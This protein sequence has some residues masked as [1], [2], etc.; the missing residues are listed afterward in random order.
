MSP[1]PPLADEASIGWIVHNSAGGVL[2]HG[3]THRLASR[4]QTLALIARDKGCSFPG[5]ADPPEWTEKHH[6]TPWRHGG[7]TDLDNLTSH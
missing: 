1:S 2:N 7:R 5:C 6:V 3:R 4:S